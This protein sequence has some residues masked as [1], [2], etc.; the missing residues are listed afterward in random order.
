VHILTSGALISAFYCP[1]PSL[2]RRVVSATCHAVVLTK[3]E[4]LRAKT[5]GFW[6]C[7]FPFSLLDSPSCT[8]T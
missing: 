1:L 2:A 8:L 5:A 3:A 6:F 7:L 4:A